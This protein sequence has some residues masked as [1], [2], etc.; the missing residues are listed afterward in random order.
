MSKYRVLRGSSS[1]SDS[2]L[3]LTAIRYWTA[4]EYRGRS[5]GFRIVIKRRKP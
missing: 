1:R 4:P 2:R 3:L 5:N